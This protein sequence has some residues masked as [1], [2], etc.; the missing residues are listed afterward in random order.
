MLY[1]T[2]KYES[3]VKAFNAAYPNIVIHG[4]YCQLTGKL[5]GESHE[6][7]DLVESLH[8]DPE[9]IADDIAVRLFASMRPSMF[10]N[11]MNLDSLNEYRKSRPVESL[12][13]L[14][15]RLMTPLNHNGNTLAIHH[16]R[17]NTYRWCESLEAS[18]VTE[19]VEAL[20][21]VDARLNLNGQFPDFTLETL[22]S[23][24]ILSWCAKARVEAARLERAR[25]METRWYR[26]GNTLAK[27][28]NAAIFFESKPPSVKTEKQVEKRKTQALMDNILT[29]LMTDT[30]TPDSLSVNL[31]IEPTAKPAKPSAGL[32]FLKKKA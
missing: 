13:W 24:S 29:A 23:E 5:I 15:N 17:I 22:S 28:A 7:F 9:E 14:L 32:G 21:H 20:I 3:V 31:T 11:K 27:K 26:D 10:W 12:A 25:D 8:G 2:D 18:V 4:I 6:N 1:T 30:A 16:D 19:L